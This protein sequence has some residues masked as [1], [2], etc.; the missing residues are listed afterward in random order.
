M[1]LDAARVVDTA[2]AIA[3]AESLAASY[4]TCRRCPIKSADKASS[5]TSGFS[6]RSRMTTSSLQ[7]IPSTRK[8]ASA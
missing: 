3:D 2:A 5:P 4:L 1:G 7:S 8:T 6:R